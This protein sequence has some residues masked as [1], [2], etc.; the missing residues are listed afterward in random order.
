MEKISE[1]T[2]E[3]EA[4]MANVRDQFIAIG[5]ST[6]RVDFEKSKGI[7]TEMLRQYDFIAPRSYEF[8]ASPDFKKY[9]RNYMTGSMESYWVGYGHF[10]WKHFGINDKMPIMK[11]YVENVGCTFFGEDVT[12]I[13][14]R[15]QII[16]FDD[17]NLLH[18][19]DG[20]AIRYVDGFSVYSWHGTR[21][22]KHFIEEQP[23][24]EDA[25]THENVEIRRAG[26]EILGWATILEKLGGRTIDKDPDPEIG[27][28][29]EVTIPEIGTERFLRV[30]CGTDREFAIPVEPTTKT[31]LQ[32]Q[33]RI[34]GFT[35][36]SQFIKPEIRT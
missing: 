8:V 20:P 4:D 23:T 13:T 27:E 14:D 7:V 31:A 21:V 16:A 17:R 30:R 32:A 29:V 19:E 33:A 28:L 2:P 6:E 22:P 11:D 15:P 36:V 25:L 24:I 18:R 3:Q 34:A 26:C 9:G 35:D 1:L 5:L 12:Y 10:F